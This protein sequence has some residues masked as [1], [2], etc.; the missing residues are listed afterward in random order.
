M[1]ENIQEKYKLKPVQPWKTS[2]AVPQNAP[3]ATLLYGVELEIEGCN[4]EMVVPGMSWTEDG[5]LRN[6]GLEFITKPMT[7]S[8]LVSVLDNFFTK[9]SGISE[10]NYSERCSVHVHTNVQDMTVEQLATLCMIYQVFEGVL[11][12]YV[13]ADRRRNIFCVPW[14]ET[15]LNYRSIWRMLKQ[16]ELV[17]HDW[18]KYTALNLLPVVGQGSIEWRHMPGTHDRARIYEWCRL[19]GHMYQLAKTLSFEQAKA[20]FID[21]NTTSHYYSVLRDVF[22]ED[23]ECLQVPNIEPLME[24]GVLNLKY[25]LLN[26]KSDKKHAAQWMDL[27]N[28]ELQHMLVRTREATGRIQDRP[29]PYQIDPDGRRFNTVILDDIAPR[30]EEWFTTATATATL[31]TE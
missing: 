31:R 8:N 9:N 21:L 27:T 12:E 4:T 22:R 6:S 15:Q 23:A 1:A 30:N 3:D 10:A 13:G 24:N 2:K 11:F 17:F 14:S 25:A 29:T 20:M 5:S 26:K 16:D 7:Y 28:E 18:Q 19:I